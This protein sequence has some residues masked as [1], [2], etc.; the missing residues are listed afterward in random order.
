[1][2]CE[3]LRAV[4][5]PELDATA[6][7]LVG[8]LSRAA[9]VALGLTKRCVNEGL[10]G[11][12]GEAMARESMALELS[13]RTGDFREGLAAFRERRDPDFTGR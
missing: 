3:T 13:S 10:D 12:I 9:T 11:G 1:M 8:E 4:P 5:A 2:S 6:D 7:A